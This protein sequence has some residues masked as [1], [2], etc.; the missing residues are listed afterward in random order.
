MFN[1]LEYLL[2]IGYCFMIS[3]VV[4]VHGNFV[5]RFEALGCIVS[6]DYLLDIHVCSII[7]RLYEYA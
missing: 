6:T 5:Q 1:V 3:F 4:C 2:M 7:T